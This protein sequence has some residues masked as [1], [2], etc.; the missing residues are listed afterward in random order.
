MKTSNKGKFKAH[1]LAIQAS[2][3]LQLAAT[4]VQQRQVKPRK[5]ASQSQVRRPTIP[6]SQQ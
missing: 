1:T 2:A 3:F 6:E 4:F 5:S